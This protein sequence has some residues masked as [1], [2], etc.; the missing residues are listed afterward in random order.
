M[1]ALAGMER[2]LTVEDAAG[3]FQYKAACGGDGFKCDSDGIV[4]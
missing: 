3:G 2:A 1:E 4:D